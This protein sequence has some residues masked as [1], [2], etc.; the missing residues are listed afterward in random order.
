MTSLR[1]LTFDTKVFCTVDGNKIHQSVQAE[2]VD[3]PPALICQDGEYICALLGH[4]RCIMMVSCL[5]VCYLLVSPL[6]V[7]IFSFLA[8][9][10]ERHLVET[11]AEFIC[12]EL[13]MCCMLF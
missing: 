12:T 7:Y 4:E 3:Q 5:L 11:R 13:F 1:K 10:N 9:G 8:R 6:S 2:T